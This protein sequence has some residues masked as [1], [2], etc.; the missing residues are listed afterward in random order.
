MDRRSAGASILP[1]EPTRAHSVVAPGLVP[2]SPLPCT[3]TSPGY[4]RSLTDRWKILACSI[5]QHWSLS[6][7]P[8][9]SPLGW[10]P[11]GPAAHPRAVPPKPL[12]LS[13]LASSRGLFSFHQD[14]LHLSYSPYTFW[15]PQQ[16]E[17]R[18]HVHTS[19]GTLLV[20]GVYGSW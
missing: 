6:T 11:A 1:K 8:P 5:Y 2:S 12:P 4:P 13:L 18:V 3:W 14:F 16:E 20:G 10:F 19:V 17:T 15:Q 9:P 7:L